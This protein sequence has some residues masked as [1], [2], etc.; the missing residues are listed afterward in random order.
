M[1]TLTQK[2]I[3]FLIRA[4]KTV[5]WLRVQAGAADKISLRIDELVKKLGG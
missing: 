4:L 1:E 2:D 3:T 5:K